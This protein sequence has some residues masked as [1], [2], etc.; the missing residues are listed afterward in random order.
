MHVNRRFLLTLAAV[1]L[2]GCA[3][4]PPAVERPLPPAVPEA[5][6]AAARAR[7]EAV[8]RIEAGQS[9]VVVRVYRGGRLARLGHDHVV[10]SRA[11]EGLVLLAPAPEAMRA[12]L[13]MALDSLTVDEPELRTAAG[14]DTTPGAADI[15]A[16]RRNMLE[17]T[18]DAARHPYVTLAITHA[19]GG[20]PA[21][22]LDVAIT[23]HGVTRHYP[24]PVQIDTGDGRLRARGRLALRQTDHGIT[25]FSVF[26]GAL[27]VQDRLDLEFDLQARRW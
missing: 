12:D 20:L 25:P 1:L 17:R 14:L 10:A 11:V 18:L 5:D 27:E 26:G 3:P 9:L 23:L 2:A 16:T 19:G 4:R 21:P 8:Y 24:V 13:V 15:E 7:G 6:Y 22:T